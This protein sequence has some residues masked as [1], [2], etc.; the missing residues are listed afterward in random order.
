MHRICLVD[1]TTTVRRRAPGNPARARGRATSTRVGRTSGAGCGRSGCAARDVEKPP[2]SATPTVSRSPTTSERRS[3]H[4]VRRWPATSGH[5]HRPMPRQ[6]VNRRRLGTWDSQVIRLYPDMLRHRSPSVTSPT[7]GGL[8][9]L[10]LPQGP[11]HPAPPL[12]AGPYPFPALRTPRRSQHPAYPAAPAS[13]YPAA[14]EAHPS[15]APTGPRHKKR[16]TGI[17]VVVLAVAALVAVGATSPL[18]W[19]DS[20]PTGKTAFPQNQIA[21]SGGTTCVIRLGELYCWGSNKNGQVGDG[22]TTD[23]STPVKVPGLTDVTAVY[24]GRVT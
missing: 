22:S 15:P 8:P 18:W 10:P 12:S 3:P 19:P 21:A 9:A 13:G 5:R 24:V 20:T 16:S 4:R 7:P 17:I 14:A 11:A 2:P 6:P 23:R 1:G